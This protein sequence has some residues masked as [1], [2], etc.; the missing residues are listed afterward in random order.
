MERGELVGVNKK[1]TTELSLK[2]IAGGGICFYLIGNTK[3]LTISKKFRVN[4]GK[5]GGGDEALIGL[6]K[7]D[8]KILIGALN[9]YMEHM[10]DD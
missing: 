2:V 6:S 5:I 3:N 8:I 1:V 4:F 9:E 10:D 7:K